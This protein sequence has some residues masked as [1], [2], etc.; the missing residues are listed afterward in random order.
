MRQRVVE[1]LRPL[2]AISVENFVHPGTADVNHVGGW[3]ELKYVAAWPKRAATPLRIPHFTGQQRTWLTRRVRAGG[4]ADLLLL[5][6]QQWLLF[7]GHTAA[8]VV[9]HATRTDLERVARWCW[10]PRL[11]DKELIDLV[12]P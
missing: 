11:V 9:G 12:K 4:R 10:S 5:V 7:D 1:A 6:E 8:A 2:D 3:M